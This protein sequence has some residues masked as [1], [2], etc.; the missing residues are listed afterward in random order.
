MNA[1]FGKPTS[2]Y[3]PSKSWSYELGYKAS[4]NSGQFSVA[5]FYNDVE[6]EQLM[7]IDFS[8][9][10]FFPTNLDTRSSGV[11]LNSNWSLSQQWRLGLALNWT[12][13]KLEE[14]GVS[15]AKPGNWVPNVPKFASAIYID[16]EGESISMNHRS[17]TPFLSLSHAYQSRR[18]ADVGNNFWLPAYHQA[19]FRGGLRLNHWEASIF[20]QNLTDKRP[21]ISGV[22]FGPGVN[23][24]NYGRG[25]IAGIALSAT[26]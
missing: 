12:R 19:D 17:F 21:E 26:F 7:T 23:V 3:A 5:A 16:Y 1:A 22:Q 20:V 4:V 13:A 24:V 8:T 25:R 18:A 9:F 14:V 6:D 2:P 15:Q 10:Q 11:E